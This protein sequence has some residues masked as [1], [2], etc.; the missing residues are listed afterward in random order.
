MSGSKVTSEK[1]P[2]SVE[3]LKSMKCLSDNN[4]DKSACQQQFD[5]Y[6]ECKKFWGQVRLARRA[7][8]IYPYMPPEKDRAAMKIKYIKT[9]TIPTTPD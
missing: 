2:C 6:K 1:D 4:Y 7:N 9:G 5:N 8:G 3:S